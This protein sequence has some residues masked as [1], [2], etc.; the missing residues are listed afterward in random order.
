MPVRRQGDGEIVNEETQPVRRGGDDKPTEPAESVF[1]GDSDYGPTRHIRQPGES[2]FDDDDD[3]LSGE[4]LFGDDRDRNWDSPTEPMRGQK[5]GRGTPEGREGRT[6]VYRGGRGSQPGVADDA[7]DPMADPPVGWLVVVGGPGKG[8]VLTLGSGMNA[9][10]RSEE[11]R[12]RLDFGDDNV[13]RRNHARLIYEPRQRRWLLNHGDGT[14]LTYLNG[15]VVVGI[16]EIESGAEIQ[17]GD[18]TMRFQA[19]CSR[20]FDWQDVDD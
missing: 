15:D 7:D 8:R 9:I 1:D 10:G 12:V 3:R 2:L 5:A 6:R 18:T 4:S 20:E 14:N 17:L 13:S 16:A 11:S 19:F